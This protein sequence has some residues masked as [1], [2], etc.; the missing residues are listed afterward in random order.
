[1]KRYSLIYSFIVTVLSI[2]C[3]SA[4]NNKEPQASNPPKEE[5]I[6]E[7]QPAEGENQGESEETAQEQT[8]ETTEEWTPEEQY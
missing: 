4:C 5:I 3:I 8:T 1:M 2:I 6:P 7:E